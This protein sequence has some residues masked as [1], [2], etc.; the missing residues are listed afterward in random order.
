MTFCSEKI[1]SVQKQIISFVTSQMFVRFFPAFKFISQRGWTSDI[2][3]S[4]LVNYNA[5]KMHSCCL[6]KKHSLIHSASLVL[7]CVRILSGTIILCTPLY[8]LET[9]CKKL[10]R[11]QKYFISANL[12]TLYSAQI[13]T[14]F[15]YYS[16]VS[17]QQQHICQLSWIYFR[18]QLLIWSPKSPR[19]GTYTLSQCCYHSIAVLQVLYGLCSLELFSMMMPWLDR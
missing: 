17:A 13:R 11:A 16:H 1:V 9:S 8:L 6:Y 18:T 3:I 2:Q 14:E 7:K 10:F 19:T 12:V 5:S 4:S 15:E